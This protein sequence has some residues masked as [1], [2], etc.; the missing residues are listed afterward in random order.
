MIDSFGTLLASIWSSL[1]DI[2]I[3]F[4]AFLVARYIANSLQLHA[5]GYFDLGTYVAESAQAVFMTTACIFLTSHLLGPTVTISVFS[6]FSMGIGY[7]LQPY[8]ISLLAGLNFQAMGIVKEN[9]IIQVGDENYKVLSVSL[10]YICGKHE[11]GSLTY[12]PNAYF[13]EIPLTVSS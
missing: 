11:S 12:F 1:D 2:L 3:C 5:I 6:G 9:N 13:Q 4:G 10:L 8:I 7:A